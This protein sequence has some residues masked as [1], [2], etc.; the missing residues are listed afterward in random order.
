MTGYLAMNLAL[1]AAEVALAAVF[2]LG[3]RVR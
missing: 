3:L 1:A 2:W